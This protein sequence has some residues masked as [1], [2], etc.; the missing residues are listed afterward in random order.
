MTLSI[1]SHEDSDGDY[2]AAF[3]GNECRGVAERMYFPFGDSYM[4]ALMVY[5]NET[6]GEELTFKYYNSNTG[7]IVDYYETYDFTSDMIV[8]NGFGTFGL[9]R[10]LGDISS[11][12]T[13]SISDAYPN[14]FNPVTSFEYT[15]V[16]AGM[17]NVAVYDISGRMVAELVNDYMSAGTY[18]VT[19]NANELSSGVYMLNM[20]AG[21]FATVQKVILIK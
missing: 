4:Y 19:W 6:S 13:A 11:L 1:D 16:E 10:E 5:S 8:G 3:V 17:V 15:L 2:I 20:I 21:D 9:S 12:T 14:P 7:E 18:P